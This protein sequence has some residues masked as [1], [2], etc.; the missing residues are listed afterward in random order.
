ML[1]LAR[2]YNVVLSW[3]GL[4]FVLCWGIIVILLFWFCCWLCV[5]MFACL[6]DCSLCV[7]AVCEEST[8]S[9]TYTGV[10]GLALAGMVKVTP[11]DKVDILGKAG[12]LASPPERFASRLNGVHPLFWQERKPVAFWRQLLTDLNV[13]AVCDI[14]PGSGTLAQ[15]CLLEHWNYTGI[16]RTGAHSSFMQNKLDRDA[17]GVISMDGSGMYESDLAHH[18][19][20]H[21]GDV[22]DELNA[23]EVDDALEGA[24]TESGSEAE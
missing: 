6:C 14:T 5:C 15:A 24:E 16:T 19:Q 1:A 11:E 7:F 8:H 22:V 23:A 9:K 4:L 13:K 18:L 10:S 17:V 20:T 2:V 3:G 12:E 21:F